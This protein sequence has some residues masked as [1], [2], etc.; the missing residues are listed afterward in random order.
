MN[1]VLK[2]VLFDLDG[3]FAD[4]APDLAYALN[5]TLIAWDQEPLAY[6]AIRP[7]VSHGGIALIRRGF[8]MEPEEE[9]FEERRQYLLDVYTRN[10]CRETRLFTGMSELLEHLES[11]MIPWGIVTNKPA[12]LTD[13]L[14]LELQL[15]DR[16]ACIVSGDTCEK[17]KPHPMPL[18]HASDQMDLAPRHC[19][20]VGD[21]ER[22]IQAGRSA[23]M[24][25]ATALWGYLEEIDDPS[26]WQADWDIKTPTEILGL[27]Q[28][29][30]V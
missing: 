9:G 29:T 11:R 12:W 1:S 23:G 15:T 10:I 24:K 27:L 8:G 3:T 25:T 18:L 16:A 6:E 22:D 4:T 20:Y 7:V 28:Q 26:A 2:A 17:N 14:M 5:Q 30:T 21:A 13:P 19:L